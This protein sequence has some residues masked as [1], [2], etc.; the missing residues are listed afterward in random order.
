MVKSKHLSD[1]LKTD[2]PLF[3]SHTDGL[4]PVPPSTSGAVV[5]IP[6]GAQRGEFQRQQGS[7]YVE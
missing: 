2:L 5:V 6:H 4:P 7:H 1:L 3:P